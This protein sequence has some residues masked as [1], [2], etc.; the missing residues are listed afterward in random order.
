MRSCNWARRSLTAG[1]SNLCS[2]TCDMPGPALVSTCLQCHS[3]VQAV[4]SADVPKHRRLCI[5]S[6]TITHSCEQ[7]YQP[8]LS[9]CKY[10]GLMQLHWTVN[11][12]V[13]MQPHWTVNRVVPMQLYWTVN[14]VVPSRRLCHASAW[15][16]ICRANCSSWLQTK[17][18]Q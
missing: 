2:N 7:H 17:V 3:G 13:S 12:V 1:S 11:G 4:H 5:K 8:Y 6:C 18:T 10:T 14:G 16:D 9:R 15:S